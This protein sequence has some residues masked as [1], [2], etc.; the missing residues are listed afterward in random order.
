MSFDKTDNKFPI[1]MNRYRERSDVELVELLKADDNRAFEEIY[2]RYWKKLFTIASNKLK[3][4]YEAEEVV[5][6]I[7]TMFWKRRNEIEITATLSAYLAVSVKYSIIKKISKK[8][9][10]QKYTE[11]VFYTKSH[12][13]NSTQEWLEFDELKAELYKAVAA[14]PEK[15]RIVYRLSREEGLS[16]KQIASKLD[17]SEKT[18]EA[19]IG[20]AIKRLKVVFNHLLKVIILLVAV[21]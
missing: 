4:N 19:H 10:H 20:K 13:D 5:Q 9:T 14:L 16:Q 18:V 7:F 3:C 8:K 11:N 21:Q 1:N 15:C 12:L 6:D 2:Y 17:I